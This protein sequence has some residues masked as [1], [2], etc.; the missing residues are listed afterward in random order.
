MAEHELKI[1]GLTKHYGKTLALD[2]VNLTMQTGICGLLGP[3]GAGKSTLINLITD[4]V[5]RETGSILWDGNEILKM[6]A[7]FRRI[8]GYMPQQ[9]GYYA[10]A[11]VR[12]VTHFGSAAS[13][14]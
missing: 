10:E 4:N 6:G 11:S 9:Q 2:E 14:S 3:N 13:D 7:G 8:L 12:A 5:K 1:S